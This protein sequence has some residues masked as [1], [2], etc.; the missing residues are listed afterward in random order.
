MT[1]AAAIGT[2]FVGVSDN[3]NAS[4]TESDASPKLKIGIIGAMKSEVEELKK[5]A[6]VKEPFTCGGRDF[7]EGELG[8]VK[9][10]IV[11]CGI[12][13][14]N[15]ALCATVLTVRYGVSHII[16]TGVAGSLNNAL[17]VGDIVVSVDA[18]QHDYDVS[19]IG[20]RKG[21]VPFTGKYAF[22]A[23]AFMRRKA[24][25]TAKDVLPNVRVIEGRIASGDQFI[26]SKE[27]KAQIVNEFS[28]DCT[29]MEGAAIAQV[30]YLSQVPFVV[31]RA[32]SD[33]ADESAQVSFEEF[34]RQAAKNSARL[35]EEMVPKFKESA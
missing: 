30:A 33:K 2:A 29:E 18:V 35:V 13:K 3:A 34:Q 24:L 19:H 27:Q 4:A 31:L 12:G 16:N 10:V 22:E 6:A 26:A 25:E 20:F 15:A 7:F 5:A 23:D 17:N 21:E 28:A 1:G 8:G 14:V 9:V 11:E 32:I